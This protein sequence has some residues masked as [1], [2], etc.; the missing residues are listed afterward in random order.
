MPATNLPFAEGFEPHKMEP[1][2][3]RNYC[4]KKNKDE[5]D[6]S[7]GDD[8]DNNSDHDNDNDNDV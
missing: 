5:N 1:L 8:A 7:N 4:K 3:G 2:Q 6:N